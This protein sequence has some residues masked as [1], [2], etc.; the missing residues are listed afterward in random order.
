MTE[1][2]VDTSVVLKWFH[3][4]GE[5]DVDEARLLLAAHRDGHVT[6]RVLDLAV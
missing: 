2:L 5:A 6:A 3:S 1:L 4:D